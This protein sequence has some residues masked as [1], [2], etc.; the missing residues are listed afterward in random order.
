MCEVSE[1]KYNK[2]GKYIQ[3]FRNS[4]SMNKR[5]YTYIF[6]WVNGL[7]FNAYHF[8]IYGI[9]FNFNFAYKVQK[10]PISHSLNYHPFMH[11]QI[12]FIPPPTGYGP[13]RW[14]TELLKTSMLK[15]RDQ[16][17]K[18]VKIITYFML[19]LFFLLQQ[20][21]VVGIG[22]P[23]GGSVLP[24]AMACIKWYE[25]KLLLLSKSVDGKERQKS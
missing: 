6:E 8:S 15:V 21:N 14:M 17:R 5:I 9:S 3:F 12:I 1:L 2:Y 4:L 24:V 23:V 20:Q 18:V 13:W 10:S 7:L 11:I 16:R 25:W 22:R 19:E